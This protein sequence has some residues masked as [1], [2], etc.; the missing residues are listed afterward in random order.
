M[1]PL[2]LGIDIGTTATKA[3]LCNLEGRILAEAEAPT[4]LRS[5]YPAWAEEDPE[6]WWQ[7]IPRVVHSCLEKSGRR[8]EEIAAVGVSGMVPTLILLD[9][10]GSVLRPSIQQNDARSYREIEDF[11]AQLDE[12]D[13]LRRTGS[14]ITQQS[15]GPKLL[16]LRRHEPQSMERARHLMGSYDFIVHRLTGEFSIERNWALESGLFD[17]HREDWDDTLLTLSTIERSWLGKVHWPAEAVGQVT[18]AAAEFTGLAPGTPVVAGSADHIA[19]AFSAGLQMQG[20]LLVKL[21]GAGDILYCLETLTVDPRLFLDYHV[22]PG[23]FLINGCMA[24]SGSIIKWFRNEFAPAF[25]YAELDAEAEALTP[26]AEGLILLPY[27]LGEKTPIFDPQARG[28]FLGLTLTH[29]RAHLYRAIL[30]G[31][32]F[33]FY[34]HLQ[35]LAELGFTATRARVT[36]GGARS[37]LWKQITADVLGLPLE[38][39]AHHPGSSLGAAFIAGMGIGAFQDWDEIERYITI[40]ATTEPNMAHHTR[41]QELFYLYRRAYERLKDLFPQL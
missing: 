21:G 38:Q 11:K 5:P 13:I 30:E 22:I 28:L 16:W 25:S 32:S 7:N 6:E 20:D 35:V 36:N 2:L 18:T 10:A 24:A 12:A 9:E 8:A 17:L 27:F 19:S 23:K 15:I 29:R 14:T 31:I 3:I 39:I 34:H 41:Y 1:K 33:G 26:G 4:T 40:E 37:R